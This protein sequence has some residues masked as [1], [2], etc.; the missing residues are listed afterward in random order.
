[1]ILAGTAI[2]AH[3]QLFEASDEFVLPILKAYEKYTR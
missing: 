1:M 3:A 2:D